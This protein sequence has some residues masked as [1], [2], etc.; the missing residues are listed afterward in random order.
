VVDERLG[1][2]GDPRARPPRAPAEP[3]ILG[4][5]LAD[6]RLEPYLET[7]ERLE[8]LPPHEHVGRLVETTLP[9]DGERAVVRRAPRVGVRSNLTL[10]EFR[11]LEC[12][13]SG[14]Q[15]PTVGIAV[16]VGEAEDRAT[17]SGRSP[18][19]RGRGSGLFLT[20]HGHRP[21]RPLGD[22]GAVIDRA[23][24]DHDDFVRLGPLLPC[25]C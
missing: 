12:G 13:Q 24:V 11:V 2:E 18:V 14:R 20:H 5:R 25:Q 15:P 7:V 22:R 23:V 3:H 21:R 8:E 9:K 16:S 4:E 10:D 1:A 6:L 17:G 19:A